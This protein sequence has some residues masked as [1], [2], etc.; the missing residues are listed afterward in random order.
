MSTNMLSKWIC[1]R[2]PRKS[3]E[4]ERLLDREGENHQKAEFGRG[5]PTRMRPELISIQQGIWGGLGSHCH[6]ARS[7]SR[8]FFQ[9]AKFHRYSLKMSREF[10]Q[11]I[12]AVMFSLSFSLSALPWRQDT[13]RKKIA[14]NGVCIAIQPGRPPVAKGGSWLF[15]KDGGKGEFLLT[16]HYN[17][18]QSV[19]RKILK[20]IGAALDEFHLRMEPFCNTVVLCK[21]PHAGN[22]STPT[23]ECFRQGFYRG[24]PAITEL[25]YPV[26]QLLNQRNA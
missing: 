24:K 22:F 3:K 21:S 11:A 26:E 9:N 16:T 19:I 8:T 12:G 17:Y 20:S 18:S 10:L 7:S 13:T 1:F 2:T 14:E 23:I 5:E 6:P 15:P 4:R 25:P